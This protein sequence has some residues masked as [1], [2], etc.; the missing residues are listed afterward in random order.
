MSPWRIEPLALHR[1]LVSGSKV[2]YLAGD[3]PTVEHMR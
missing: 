2:L 1:V 3:G